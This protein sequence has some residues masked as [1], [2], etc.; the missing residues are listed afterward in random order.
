VAQGWQVKPGTAA[1]KRLK[2]LPPDIFAEME[3]R[4]LRR[5]SPAKVARWLQEEGQCKDVTLLS[6]GKQI[7]RYRRD[8]LTAQ[9]AKDFTAYLSRR[10]VG[11]PGHVFEPLD[12]L[13]E[14]TKLV[15]KQIRRVAKAQKLEDAT[16]MLTNQATNEMMNLHK[17]LQEL[18]NLYMEAGVMRRVPKKLSGSLLDRAG[19]GLRFE[20][21]EE[22]Q[23]LLSE[24]QRE[25]AALIEGRE[26]VKVLDAEV[27]ASS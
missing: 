26:D 7:T 3:N 15:R 25:L 21:S 6:L 17:M 20:V 8:Y 13:E 19:K 4:L 18:S 22:T 5:E 14:S 1:Y 27:V 10:A 11:K 24:A 12:V 16:S 9:V 2:E 23:G